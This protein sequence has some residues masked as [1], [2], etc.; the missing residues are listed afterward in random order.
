[1]ETKISADAPDLSLEHRNGLQVLLLAVELLL[2]LING[3]LLG[4]QGLF[5]GCQPL[6]KIIRELLLH[7]LK[8]E[9]IY[10]LA[11]IANRWILC[12]NRQRAA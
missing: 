6:L 1:M 5:G 3:V 2:H 8:L 4:H 12:C 7:R 10:Y 11:T 9:A